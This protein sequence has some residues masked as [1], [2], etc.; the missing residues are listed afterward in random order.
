MNNPTPISGVDNPCLLLKKVAFG[1][2][3]AWI[4]LGPRSLQLGLHGGGLAQQRPPAPVRTETG[5]GLYFAS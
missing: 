5:R 4:H 2:E 3:R 1:P